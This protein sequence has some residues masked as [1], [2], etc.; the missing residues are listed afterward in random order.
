[1]LPNL[2]RL[3][4]TCQPCGATFEEFDD[5]LGAVPPG[6]RL[7]SDWDPAGDNW[8]GEQSP[9]CAICLEP[10][11]RRA[12]GDRDASKEVEALFE[13]PDCGHAF[14]RECIE[15]HL[16]SDNNDTSLRCPTCRRPIDQMV[17]DSFFNP[18]TVQEVEADDGFGGDGGFGD[19][20]PFGG[21]G[22]YDEDADFDL[23]EGG[24]YESDSFDAADELLET[25]EEEQQMIALAYRQVVEASIPVE[26]RELWR[27]FAVAI[28]TLLNIKKDYITQEMPYDVVASQLEDIITIYNTFSVDAPAPIFRNTS[29]AIPHIL[30]K[31]QSV[32]PEYDLYVTE[33]E[34]GN[35]LELR[36]TSLT[37]QGRALEEEYVPHTRDWTSPAVTIP[38]PVIAFK[39]SFSYVLN[40][41]VRLGELPRSEFYRVRD[42]AELYFTMDRRFPGPRR[43]FDGDY[44][45][46][47]PE[48][49]TFPLR[50]KL[51]MLRILTYIADNWREVSSLLEVG[52]EGAVSIRNFETIVV[53]QN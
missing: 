48:S 37:R 17:L 52:I 40:M 25:L 4:H 22:V 36:S 15:G 3:H 7:R 13:N 38:R 2:S 46:L 34:D 45:S 30:T 24:G 44:A 39:N 49:V 1:M 28:N 10:L 14:H 50:W 16:D 27:D 26:R 32:V 29:D 8:D 9:I 5:A 21:E 51:Y 42:M 41:R 19:D 18:G 12:R 53:N 43:N 11:H 35:F 33:R 6:L 47:G 20:D 31:V 23:P